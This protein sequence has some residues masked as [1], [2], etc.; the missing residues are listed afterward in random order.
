MKNAT[1]VEVHILLNNGFTCPLTL[2]N[3]IKKELLFI[4]PGVPEEGSFTTAQLCGE[5]FW[6]PLPDWDRTLAGSCMDHLA[7]HGQVPFEN[8]PRKGRNPYPLL[9]RI[10]ASYTQIR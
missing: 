1:E 5:E 4:A 3:R 8:V 7:E 6:S 9:F 2:F 10:K